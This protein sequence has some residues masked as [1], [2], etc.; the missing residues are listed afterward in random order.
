[1]D[2][3]DQLITA[4]QAMQ[5]DLGLSGDTPVFLPGYNDSGV[6][7][8]AALRSINVARNPG[9]ADDGEVVRMWVEDESGSPAVLI[10]RYPDENP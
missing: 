1:M 3:I 10:L 6:V 7:K 5:R 8:P 2:T 4:L 9:V